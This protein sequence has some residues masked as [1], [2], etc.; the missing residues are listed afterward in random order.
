MAKK[1]K[2]GKQLEFKQDGWDKFLKTNLGMAMDTY[3]KLRQVKQEND[4]ALE[5][6]TDL[7]S[8]EMKKIGKTYICPQINGLFYE[9][10]LKLASEKLKVK[11]M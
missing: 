1:Q 4:A 8:I 10:E 2:K 6:A 11:E 9:F 3:V 7:V 5:K